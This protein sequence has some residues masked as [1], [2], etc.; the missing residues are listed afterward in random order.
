MHELVEMLKTAF[1]KRLLYVGLQGSY[2]RV[3]AT[4]KSDIDVMVVIDEMK[5]NDLKKYKKVLKEI[6][7]YVSIVCLVIVF[8]Y[9]IIM[10]GSPLQLIIIFLPVIYVMLSTRE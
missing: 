2:L 6:G 5:P 3:E 7:I 9:G 1:E 10:K 4:E 8:V